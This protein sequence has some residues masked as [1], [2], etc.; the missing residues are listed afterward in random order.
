MP[1]PQIQRKTHVIDATGQV[2]G[3]LAARIAVLLTGKHKSGYLPHLDMG[4]VVIVRNVDKIKV[5][6]KKLKQKIYYRHT[7]Y[8]GNMRE[9]PMWIIK[10]KRPHELLR[11]A[12]WGMLP[13]NRLRKRRIKRL[14]FE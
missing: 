12:V 8:L 9:I 1:K 3:R 10:E 11:R 4:D 7:G 13:K 14:K 6:G 5:T 2:L